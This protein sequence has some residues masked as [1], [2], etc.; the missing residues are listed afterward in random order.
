MIY[1]QS[2]RDFYQKQTGSEIDQLIKLLILIVKEFYHQILIFD[3]AR[4]YFN[5]YIPIHMYTIE[6]E[7]VKG[8][9]H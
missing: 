1:S 8:Q 4:Y 9:K 6:L 5:H 2:L 7:R 3:E